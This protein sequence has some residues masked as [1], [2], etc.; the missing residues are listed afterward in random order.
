MEERSTA[1]ALIDVCTQ[2][3]AVYLDWFDG[4]PHVA[5]I[6]WH[7]V[8]RTNA[9]ALRLSSNCP[10]CG[11]RFEGE[12]LAGTGSVVF[13]CTD[14]AGF[15][16]TQDAARMIAGHTEPLPSETPSFFRSLAAALRSLFSAKA[17]P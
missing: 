9:P 17:A 10:K 7:P 6:G 16:A 8:D 13:R 2:C 4:D 11:G 15:Y 3:G 14:C 5:L 1:E 12:E